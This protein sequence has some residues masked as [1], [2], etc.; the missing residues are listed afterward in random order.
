MRSVRMLAVLSALIATPLLYAAAQG[1][2]SPSDKCA[3]ADANRSANASADKENLP[4]A[5]LGERRGCSPVP[6]APPAP[7][8]PP[9]PSGSV[10]ITGKI[11]NNI[12]G[13]PGLAGWVVT[14]S[15]PYTTSAVTDAFGVYTFSSLPAGTYAICQVL[16]S[17]WTQTM[18]TVGTQCTS[19]TMGYLFTLAENSGA[20]FVNFANVVA[21]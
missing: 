18:P 9:P 2:Q 13:R 1:N 16:Q 5:T 12:T 11:Y 4:S 3:V 17:G 14:V 15:G 19:T 20:S 6:P 7:P 10:T 21:Q 8:P